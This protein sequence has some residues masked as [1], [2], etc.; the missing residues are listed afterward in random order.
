MPLIKRRESEQAGD[1]PHDV[2]AL[3][4]RKYEPCRSRER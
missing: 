1:E 4:E 3:R 2:L